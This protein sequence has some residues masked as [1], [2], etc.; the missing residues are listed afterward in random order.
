MEEIKLRIKINLFLILLLLAYNNALAYDINDKFS[1]E[2]TLT[3]VGQ[4]AA[5]DDVFDEDG[6]EVSDTTRATVVLDIGVN[7]HPTENDEFQIIY[8]FA[9]GEALNGLEA[10]SLAP[11]ADDLEEDLSDI[12]G[13]ERY[14]L[15]EAWYKHTFSFSETTS[16]GITGGIIGATGY[17]D[18]NEYAN[19]EV[20]QFMNDIFVNNTLANLPDYDVGA[21]IEFA[22]RIWSVNAVVMESEND[23]GNDFYYYA[24][25]IGHHI[26]TRFG[27]GNYR[28]YAFTTDDKF[29]DVDGTDEENL[30]GFGLSIDQKISES[31]GLF[32]RLGFQDDDVP[33]EHDEMISFGASISGSSWNRVDDTL[34]VGIA[35]LD[36]A[37]DSEINDTT[38]FEAYYQYIFSEY[39][40]I[41]IDFQYIEDSLS[42][43]DDPEGFLTGLRLNLNF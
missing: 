18:D 12:N 1:V 29:V 10:F 13:S 5:I 27:E 6:N 17:I 9:E 8:S 23:D 20:S 36:G 31:V 40:D 4:H 39:V 37:S 16:L 7:F 34:G 32:A 38:A 42:G 41:A 15:L 22:S 26:T 43:A 25:Q 21:A 3:A 28:I 33:V 11:F 24:L 19:D 35:F 30:V 14:N 2:G